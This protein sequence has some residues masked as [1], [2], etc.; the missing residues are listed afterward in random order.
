MK[1]SKVNFGFLI[2]CIGLTQTAIAGEKFFKVSGVKFRTTNAY[3]VNLGDIGV[4]KDRIKYASFDPTIK[5]PWPQLEAFVTPKINQTIK[6]SL[7]G[8]AKLKLSVANAAKTKIKGKIRKNSKVKVDY[9]VASL[10]R[11]KLIDKINADK[12][13]IRKLLQ[14][15]KYRVITDVVVVNDYKRNGSI[16][17]R[18]KAKAKIIGA[19]KAKFKGKGGRVETLDLGDGTTLAYQMAKICWYKRTAE[20]GELVTD[21]RGKDACPGRLTAHPP[22]KARRSM[23]R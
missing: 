4:R 21:L 2:L 3:V 18:G 20:V 16:K 17:F 9:Y 6:A 13:L 7:M 22:K 14:S 23:R 12:K 1:V 11:S 19:A 5:N 15:S 10:D 8:K